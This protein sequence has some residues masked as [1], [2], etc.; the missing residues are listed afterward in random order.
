MN[1]EFT[2]E[3]VSLEKV[4]YT[5]SIK[6][7]ILTATTGQM[8]V[9]PDHIAVVAAL[10]AGDVWLFGGETEFS[11]HIAAGIMEFSSNKMVILADKVD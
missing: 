8:E 2:V 6:R 10:E 7:A 3:I 9:L 11:K 1:S 5:G 4:E